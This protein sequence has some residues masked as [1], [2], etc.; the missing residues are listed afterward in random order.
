MTRIEHR[1]VP[2]LRTPVSAVGAGCWT[3]GGPAANNGVPIGWDGVD[4][5]RALAG[6]E[7]AYELGV[8]LFDTADVYGLGRSERLVGRLLDTIPREQV[9]VSSKVGYFTG[10]AAHPYLPRQMRRQLETTLDNLRT[11]YLD[12]YCFHSADF[13]PA[14][15]HLDATVAQMNAFRAEGLVGAV[16]MRAPNEFAAEWVSSPNGGKRGADAT[17]FLHLYDA[18]RPDVVMTRYNL[19]SPLYDPAETDIFALA[20]SRGTGVL[21]KQVLAQGLLLATPATAA[22]AYSEGDHRSRDPQ[23]RAPVRAAIT[24]TAQNIRDHFGDIGSRR[25]ALR[26]ALQ[27]HPYAAV[28]VGFRDAT[29]IEQNITSLGEPLTDQE[30]AILQEL[31]APVRKLLSGDQAGLPAAAHGTL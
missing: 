5:A 27:R 11:S 14:D 19:L 29:Q 7:R 30:I 12:L 26:F 9:T 6:L 28:L 22:R 8:T 23:F 13:G 20:R 31:T 1:E 4:E 24:E 2:G 10:T 21:I 16:G 15:V 18:I 17:R 3:I 25:A